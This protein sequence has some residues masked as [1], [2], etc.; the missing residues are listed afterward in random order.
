M[1]ADIDFL[2]VQ[3]HTI[4][5]LDSAFSS[6]RGFVVDETVALGATVFIGRNLARENIAEC[7]KGVV[8]CLKFDET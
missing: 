4:D 1:V 2:V 5:G 8:K 7:S 6:L 3:K